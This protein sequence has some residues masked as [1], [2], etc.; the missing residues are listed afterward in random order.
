MEERGGGGRREGEGERERERGGGGRKRRERE[1]ERERGR[2]R[3]RER[4][5]GG[6][7]GGRGGRG[8]EGRRERYDNNPHTICFLE[9]PIHHYPPLSMTQAEEGPSL[10]S[11]Y[12]ASHTMVSVVPRTL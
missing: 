6:G 2:E 1:G 10:P 12:T 4:E 11:T 3:E 7:G 5:R 8:R 9:T